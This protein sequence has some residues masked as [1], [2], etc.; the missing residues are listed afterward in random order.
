MD[1]LMKN[2]EIRKDRNK[3]KYK[4]IKLNKTTIKFYR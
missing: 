4:N 3:K 1:R 2:E